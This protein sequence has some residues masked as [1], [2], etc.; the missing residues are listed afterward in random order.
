MK[1]SLFQIVLILFSAA[2]VLSCSADSTNDVDEDSNS[3]DYTYVA[4]GDSYT[5]GE[6]IDKSQSWPEQLVKKLEESGLDFNDPKIIAKTGWTTKNLLSAM[7][8]DLTTK[9]YD[10][11]SISIGV[12]NQYQRRSINEYEEDLKVIFSKAINRSVN[13]KEGVF[14][15][16]IPDYGATPFGASNSENIGKDIARFNSVLKRVS[17]DF[18]VPFYNITPISKEARND[19]SLVANDGLHPSGKMYGLWVNSFFN[20]VYNTLEKPVE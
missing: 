14:V 17:Q 1:K 10:L 6:G 4:L 8:V 9:Q 15:L 5:I 7:N 12:N 3:Q 13:G 18:D 20:E 2:I 16:S 11:V 19:L